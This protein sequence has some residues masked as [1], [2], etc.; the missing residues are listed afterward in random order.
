MS[1]KVIFLLLI[2]VPLVI[3]SILASILQRDHFLKISEY[4][5]GLP[6]YPD[7]CYADQIRPEVLENLRIVSVSRHFHFPLTL[8]ANGELVVYRFVA[9]ENNNEF[10]AGWEKLLVSIHVRG[11]SSTFKEVYTKSFPAGEWIF[12]PGGPVAASPLL[13]EA[14]G[15]DMVKAFY[16]TN[17]L[18]PEGI[19][20]HKTKV[21]LIVSLLLNYGF[22]AYFLL[23]KKLFFD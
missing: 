21:L 23:Y 22:T 6:V 16:T 15:R 11:K 12:E 4:R 20:S 17:Y 10:V 13:F 3:L 8:V 9:P 18:F 14:A 19:F 5:G 7:R 1:K 2:T